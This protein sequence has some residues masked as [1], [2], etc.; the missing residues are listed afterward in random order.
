MAN[1]LAIYSLSIFASTIYAALLSVLGCHL[2]AR[3]RSMQSLCIGQGAML[4]A[5]LGIGVAQQL[6]SSELQ[7]AVYPFFTAVLASL[8]AFSFSEKF[9][10]KK[11]ASRNTYF[12]SVFSVLLASSYLVS[13]LFPALE[14]HMAQRYFGDLATISDAEAMTVAGMGSLALALLFLKWKSITRDS[15]DAA[16][17]GREAITLTSLFGVLSMLVIAL[18]VQVLGFLFTISC[19]FL[20]TTFMSR[21]SR[22][23]LWRHV[24]SCLV[25]AGL[26]SAT[27]FILSIYLSTVPTVPT[28]VLTMAVL[29]SGAAWL[30]KLRCS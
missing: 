4:G 8:L 18:S 14:G 19:L 2:A 1:M 15:F 28:I 10:G 26:S 27:G 13:S 5:L 6:G 16:I 12:A 21:C 3:D 11:T 25:V 20:P 24:L 23:G 9:L 29:A 7:E 17:L 22:P 30:H